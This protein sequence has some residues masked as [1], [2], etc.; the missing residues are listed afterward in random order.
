MSRRGKASVPAPGVMR[1]PIPRQLTEAEQADV[2]ARYLE[3]AANRHMARGN[4]FKSAGDN[5][6]AQDEFD[7]AVA[8]ENAMRILRQHRLLPPLEQ[9]RVPHSG[10]VS[11]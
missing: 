4:G 2:V 9:P 8:L 5:D 3:V 11:A 7:C 10:R 1:T 6:A